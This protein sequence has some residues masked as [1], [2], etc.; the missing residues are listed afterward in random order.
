[1]RLAVFAALLTGCA[2]VGLRAE[3]Q[4]VTDVATTQITSAQQAVSLRLFRESAP[5]GFT[6]TDD[7]LTAD[8]GSG[9]RVIAEIVVRG[10][11]GSCARGA[12]TADDV[13]GEIRERALTLGADAVVFARASTE[14]CDAVRAKGGVWGRG[15]AVVLGR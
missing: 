7:V 14:K 6:M 10:D 9:H 8:T 3:A 11:N 15:W 4:H 5:P 1:M 2:G 13:Y 12:P